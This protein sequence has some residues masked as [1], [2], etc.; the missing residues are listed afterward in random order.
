MNALLP[1]MFMTIFVVNF[2]M[3]KNKTLNIGSKNK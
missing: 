3:E 2:S 1:K